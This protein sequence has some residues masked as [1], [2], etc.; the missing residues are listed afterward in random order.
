[1]QYL[2]ITL[3]CIWKKKQLAFLNIKLLVKNL[4]NSR[5]AY[6]SNFCIFS[7]QN[8]IQACTQLTFYCLLTVQIDIINN[9]D[10]IDINTN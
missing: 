8:P 10:I 7:A 5:L 9:L 6:C 2:G 1:M 4:Y 3:I